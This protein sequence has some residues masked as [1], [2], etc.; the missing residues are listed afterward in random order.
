MNHLIKHVTLL[1]EDCKSKLAFDVDMNFSCEIGTKIIPNFNSFIYCNTCNDFRTFIDIDSNI[2][3]SCILLME[4][5]IQ[6]K[7]SLVRD[8]LI[9]IL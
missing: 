1:C 9:I 8:T 5:G 3:D 4:N 7:Y 2:V 6:T